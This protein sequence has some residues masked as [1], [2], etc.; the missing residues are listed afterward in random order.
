MDRGGVRSGEVSGDNVGAVRA[1]GRGEDVAH[2][3]DLASTRRSPL[4]CPDGTASN[5]NDENE[6]TFGRIQDAILACKLG[7]GCGANN[8]PKR[9]P[10]SALSTACAWRINFGW[11]GYHGVRQKEQ[12]LA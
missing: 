1:Q 11:K 7:K 2:T 9:S 10:P 5:V 4:S 6:G 3:S 12:D 8:N